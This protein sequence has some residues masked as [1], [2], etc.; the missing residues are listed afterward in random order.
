PRRTSTSIPL[1]ASKSPKDLRS[2]RAEIIVAGAAESVT[3]G[4]YIADR[5]RR[6]P[7]CALRGPG[8][9]GAGCQDGTVPA[10]DSFSRP[11]R[12]WFRAAFASPTPAQEGAWQ[13]IGQGRHALVVAPTGSGKTL[14]AFL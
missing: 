9:V 3:R 8:G 13:A 1:T 6:Q 10:L 11:T 5:T 4:P 7:V 12:E 14:S 2:P